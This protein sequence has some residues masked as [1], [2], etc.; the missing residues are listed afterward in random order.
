MADI[1]LYNGVPT[2]VFRFTPQPFFRHS[3][4]TQKEREDIPFEQKPDVYDPYTQNST[5]TLNGVIT[6][7]A[8]ATT[9]SGADES[10]RERMNIMRGWLVYKTDG[11]VVNTNPTEFLWKIR[12]YFPDAL[13]YDATD[14]N[15]YTVVIMGMDFS[16][17][18]NN[19]TSIQ[20]SI[21]F[22]E[23]GN[24]FLV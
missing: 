22:M 15:E 7:Q 3:I 8:A 4:G 23:A 21:T 2:L 20:Y 5:I 24:I 19:P 13:G 6:P 12:V 16:M 17:A 14:Y 9:V 1:E 10:I 18:E 11:T